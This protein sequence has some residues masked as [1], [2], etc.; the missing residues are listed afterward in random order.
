MCLCFVVY[1]KRQRFGVL[2]AVFLKIRVFWNVM[3]FRV[4]NT[5]RL[6]GGAYVSVYRIKHSLEDRK[7]LD[8]EDTALGYSEMSVAI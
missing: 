8:P 3:S 7:W 2:R 4:L 6:F 1:H 5:Y